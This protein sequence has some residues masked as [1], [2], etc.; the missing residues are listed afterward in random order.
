MKTLIPIVTF[1]LSACAQAPAAPTPAPER[2]TGASAT[3]SGAD[4]AHPAVLELYQSQGCSSCPPANAVL[5]ELAT[6]PDLLPLS[7]AVTYW[8]R[9]GWKDRFAQQKFTDRQWDY[10]RAQ[11]RTN[12]QTPQLI[13]NGR[14]AV[15]GSRKGEVEAAVAKFSRGRSG[16]AIETA[17][18]RI[19]IGAGKPAKPATI[20]HVSYDPRT[21]NVSIGNG[22]NGGRVLPHRNV[23][24]ALQPIGT[25]T[26]PSASFAAPKIAQGL[27]GAVLV[28]A[29]TGG[30]IVAARRL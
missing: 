30:P 10:S 3:M 6:R 14:A 8:D 12:V 13:V 11:G 22:E 15:L 25:W 1:A 20:W 4:A 24:K 18:G 23:V 17:A 28:Q 19:R 16:P 5:N 2:A 7:F 27:A 26:G 21:I 29:G 9:L